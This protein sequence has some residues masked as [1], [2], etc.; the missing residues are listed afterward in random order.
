MK[1]IPAKR[2]GDR[3]VSCD[4]IEATSLFLMGDNED[5]FTVRSPKDHLGHRFD[6]NTRRK[7]CTWEVV[8]YTALTVEN[9]RADHILDINDVKVQSLLANYP[10][11][12]ED[13]K[14]VFGL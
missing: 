3:F 5:D 1:V 8:L 14:T 9:T 12:Q 13:L 10:L 7:E 4:T 11:C 6:I 2:E